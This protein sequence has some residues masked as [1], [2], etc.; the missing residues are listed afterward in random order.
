ML[1]C[2]PATSEQHHWV[3]PKLSRFRHHQLPKFVP[4]NTYR[5][6]TGHSPTDTSTLPR[7]L[8]AHM[9]TLNQLH[10]TENNRKQREET[11]KNGK[12]REKTTP[13]N[14][15]KP[16]TTKQSETQRTRLSQEKNSLIAQAKHAQLRK[17]KESS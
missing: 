14:A 4:R 9:F 5:I 1:N 3:V 10:A 15:P 7:R 17:L 12:Q 6:H 2:V 11:G 16:K 13:A 8:A